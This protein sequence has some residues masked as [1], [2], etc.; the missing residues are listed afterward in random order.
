[1][2]Q[3]NLFIGALATQELIRLQLDGDRIVHEE[4]LL[5]DLGVRIRDVRQ[6]PD[7]YLDLLTDQKDGQLL[8]LGLAR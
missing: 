2:W 5:G 6:G 3:H 4:R 7:G 8:R 1:A